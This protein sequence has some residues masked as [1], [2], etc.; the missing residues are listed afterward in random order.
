MTIKRNLPVYVITTMAVLLIIFLIIHRD[1]ATQ[2]MYSQ[3]AHDLGLALMLY[4]D[5][6]RGQLPKSFA[7]LVPDPVPDQK[8]FENMTL[9]Q[10]GAL[11]GTLQHNSIIVRQS[12]ASLFGDIAVVTADGGMDLQHK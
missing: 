12:R 1:R 4:A 10:P 5:D 7:D 2:N 9:I 6:H 3:N 8:M 11:L